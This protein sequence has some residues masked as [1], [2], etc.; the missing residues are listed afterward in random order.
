VVA[1]LDARQR[2]HWSAGAAT[3]VMHAVEPVVCTLRV[4]GASERLTAR[5]SGIAPGAFELSSSE[6]LPEGALIEVDG[7]PPTLRCEG[8]V[9]GRVAFVDAPPGVPARIRCEAL[10]VSDR[11]PLSLDSRAGNTPQPISRAARTRPAT[12]QLEPTALM[13]M[14]VVL[15]VMAGLGWMAVRQSAPAAGGAPASTR[16]VLDGIRHAFE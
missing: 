2:G 16:A 8:G 1:A 5:W 7:V 13:G 6:H 9:F 15:L 4:F 11:A 14:V 12:L 3:A 10:P